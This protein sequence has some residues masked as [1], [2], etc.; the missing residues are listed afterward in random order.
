VRPSLKVCIAISLVLV[1]VVAP[2]SG[3]DAA[4]TTSTCFRINM[5]G[6]PVGWDC[7]EI[8]QSDERT[9][10]RRSIRIDVSVLLF[11][12]YEY[13][14]E[15]RELWRDGRLV[16]LETWTNDNGDEFHVQARESD[17]AIRVDRG[18]EQYQTDTGIIPTSY[19]NSDLV[20]QDKLLDT[21]TGL[22]R[23]VRI[24]PIE[25]RVVETPGG[26][27]SVQE[28]RMKGDVRL[29]LGYDSDGRWRT[30]RFKRSGYQFRYEERAVNPSSWRRSD[31]YDRTMDLEMEIGDAGET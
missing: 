15:S 8:Q 9:R 13:R 10:V 28:Y 27:V 24:E 7:V 31:F 14:H 18:A 16:R 21:Q 26:T 1:F 23:S 11:N 5:D 20:D 29:R 4:E 2:V 25:R 22:I 17:G 19:W 30:M 6:D 3:Q 12:A